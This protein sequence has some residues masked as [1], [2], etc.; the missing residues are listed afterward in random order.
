[1]FLS[2]IISTL[3]P[4]VDPIT[5][6]VSRSLQCALEAYACR[7]TGIS[8]ELESRLGQIIVLPR[9]NFHGLPVISSS[10]A[11]LHPKNLNLYRFKSEMVVKSLLP[12]ET[13]LQRL[14]LFGSQGR[15]WATT[16]STISKSY[17]MIIYTIN[18]HRLQ[19]GI[20][21][22]TEVK[23]NS[24]IRAMRLQSI[25]LKDTTNI[26][27][28][29]CPEWGWDFRLAIANEREIAWRTRIPSST[30]AATQCVTPSEG[31][32]E[33]AQDAVLDLS[34][35]V[36][37]S[38][39]IRIRHRLPIGPFFYVDL[40]KDRVT[41]I[42]SNFFSNTSELELLTIPFPVGQSPEAQIEVEVNLPALYKAWRRFGRRRRHQDAAVAGDEPAN[43]GRTAAE[44]CPHQTVDPFLRHVA[45]EWLALLQFM[46]SVRPNL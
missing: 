1:M 26:T 19:Y 7:P 21:L 45:L 16:S 40:S 12:M 22:S 6:A 17:T 31:D 36:P 44:V 5:S 29:F 8:I 39:R 38:T 4:Y 9:L 13:G 37:N 18:G 32:R 20:P 41:H 34:T 11:V 3:P 27:D 43:R 33:G 25:T 14:R 28:V 15:Q 24:H 42:P 23:A 30:N 2:R 35:I 10:N 46:C